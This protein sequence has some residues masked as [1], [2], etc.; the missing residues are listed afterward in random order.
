MSLEVKV[1]KE[2][3]DFEPKVIGPFTFRQLICLAICVPIIWVILKFLS[4][5]ITIDI[6]AFLCF[7]VAAIAFLMGWYEPYGMKTEKFIRSVFVNRFLAP[8]HR[9]YKTVNAH[10]K[11]FRELE[12]TAVFVTADTD[13]SQNASPNGQPDMKRYRLSPKAYR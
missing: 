5:I 6:A 13:V 1:T 8:S 4:P 7:P 12:E 2:I 10:E 11:L 3:R 9:K